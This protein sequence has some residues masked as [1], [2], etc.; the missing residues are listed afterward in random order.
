MNKIK[1]CFGNIKNKK[2]TALPLFDV[3]V[4]ANNE[5]ALILKSQKSSPKKRDFFAKFPILAIGEYFVQRERNNIIVQDNV[6]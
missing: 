5:P 2:Y 3:A 1:K 4:N 6:Q